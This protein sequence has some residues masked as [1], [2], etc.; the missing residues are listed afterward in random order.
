MKRTFYLPGI[1]CLALMA[2]L[3]SPPAG[4]ETWNLAAD[5]SDTTNPGSVWRYGV[6]SSD[7]QNFDALFETHTS[8]YAGGADFPG[9]PNPGWYHSAPDWG[10]HEGL[11]KSVGTSAWDFPAGRVGGHART[12]VVWTAPRSATVNISGGLWMWRDI[13]RTVNITLAVRG[14]LPLRNVPIPPRSAGVTSAAPYSL[15]RAVADSGG[16]PNALRNVS[17]N[18]GDKICLRLENPAAPGNNDFA[19]M[20]LVITENA[21]PPPGDLNGMA[22]DGKRGSPVGGTSAQ[23]LFP[24]DLPGKKWVQFQADGFRSPVWGVIYR[25]G[26][27]QPGVPLGGIGTGWIDLDTTGKFGSYTIFNQWYPRR[28]VDLAFLGLA[29]AGQTW[30]LAT[31]QIPGVTSASKIHYWGHYPVADVEYDTTAPV[32]VGL[33]AWSPFIPGDA[34]RSNLPAAVFEVHLRNPGNEPQHGRLAFSVPGWTH[35]YPGEK[36]RVKRTETSGS[37]NGLVIS[38]GNE[39]GYA[40]GIIGPGKPQIGAELGADGKAWAAVG[41]GLPAFP[42]SYQS[43]ASVAVDFDLPGNGS[44]TVRFLLAWYQPWRWDYN[45]YQNAYGLRF[46]SAR[47]VAEAVARDSESLRRRVLAWQEIIYTD[48]ELPGWLRDTLVNNFHLMAKAGHW[49]YPADHDRSWSGGHGLFSLTESPD[50]PQQECVPSNWYATFPA[51]YFFPDLVRTTCETLRHFQRADGAIA[52]LLGGGGQGPDGGEGATPY[53]VDEPDAWIAQ[54]M[55]CGSIYIQQIDRIWQRTRDDKML[56]EFYPSIKRAL[57]WEAKFD[58]QALDLQG[59]RIET[60]ADGLLDCAGRNSEQFYDEWFWYGPAIQPNG[61]WLATIKIVERMAGAMGDN[62][63]AADC[64]RR[65]ARTATAMEKKL[66]NGSYY[67]LYNDSRTGKKSD[68]ILANQLTGEFVGRFH[69]IGGVF[70]AENVKKTLTTVA[71]SALPVSE[72]GAL[73]SIRP[74]GTVDPDAANTWGGKSSC[75]IR[76]FFGETM[77]LA[78]TYLYQGDREHGLDL[79]QKVAR[80]Y[81]IVEGR[82]WDASAT[83]DYLGGGLGSHDYSQYMSFWAVPAA[84]YGKDIRAF[85]APGGLVDRVIQAGKKP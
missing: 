72:V 32:Q 48:N 9:G 6:I 70:P 62:A 78:S 5:W 41:R 80:T 37:F 11:A 84:L 24:I 50:C 14:Q 79:A 81:S 20:D 10:N 66:W 76:V 25:N 77:C 8:N 53:A 52:F 40:I 61:L 12:G 29:V 36:W 27:A 68:T 46:K 57:E 21:A 16:N 1:V 38:K 59:R 30:V 67:L 22:T 7:L 56:R 45:L 26:E 71:R 2:A 58:T 63:Y 83:A 74:D 51:I 31:D 49:V 33:R 39:R 75:P 13:G 55:L 43:G 85:C 64:R 82:P 73:S 69:G 19:G 60:E 42:N 3:T 28:K 4:A 23:R 34:E 44:K 17:V 15:D 54:E 65:A 47:D 35:E 18:A